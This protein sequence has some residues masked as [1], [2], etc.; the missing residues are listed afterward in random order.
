[1]FKILKVAAN[2]TTIYLAIN[3]MY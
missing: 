1:M 2:E 3:N